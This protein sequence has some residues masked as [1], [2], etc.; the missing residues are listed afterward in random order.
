MVAA[1]NT[2]GVV[3]LKVD[4]LVNAATAAEHAGDRETAFTLYREALFFDPQHVDAIAGMGRL[5]FKAPAQPIVD[6]VRRLAAQRLCEVTIELR[7][8]CNYRCFYCVA[9]GHNNEPVRRIDL[10]KI[11]AIYQT[12][13]EKVIVTGLECGGGEPT[14]HPQFPELVR[15]ASK[16][17]AVSFPSN[18]SQSPAR[19]LP[20]ETARRLW[21]RSAFHPEAEAKIDRYIA[22]ARYLIERE[23]MFTSMFISH[24]T[25]IASIPG[26][27][28]AF[29]KADIPF[30]PIPF[31]GEYEGRSY[32]HAHTDEERRIIGLEDGERLWQ[33]Q[34]QPST[35]RIRNFRGI[36]CVAGWRSLYIAGDGTL[37]RCLYDGRP[38]NARAKQSEPCRVKHCGCGL[39]LDKLNTIDDLD[40]YNRWAKLAEQEELP[41]NWLQDAAARSGHQAVQNALA[42]EHTAMYEALMEAHG[43]N[44]G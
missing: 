10:A 29:A 31:I 22:N 39:M 18:N 37:R 44:P 2:A 16:Y 30:V 41:S 9:E 23:V 5:R 34:I 19:W 8:P 35:N 38:L 17:G 11:E 24:P 26:Y 4:T 32:P 20:E 40:S 21:M 3:R 33:H 12:I 1:I 25:R 14:V 36:P 28:A 13:T 43:K 6:E 15:L 27:R 7:N 42:E